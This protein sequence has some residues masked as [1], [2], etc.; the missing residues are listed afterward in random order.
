MKFYGLIVRD[1]N[2]Y[3]K[4]LHTCKEKKDGIKLVL[5]YLVDNGIAGIV[6]ESEFNPSSLG[7]GKW[8][9]SVNADNTKYLEYQIINTGWVRDYFHYFTTSELNIVEINVSN[10]PPEIKEDEL[11][12]IKKLEREFSTE[13]KTEEKK[14]ASV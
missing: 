8:L 1:F 10:Q 3:P 11:S 12:P 4:V 6:K 14:D 9:V 13:Q 2:E 5:K 7:C